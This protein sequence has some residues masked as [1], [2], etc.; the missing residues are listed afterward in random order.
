MTAK[1]LP[2]TTANGDTTDMNNNTKENNNKAECLCHE[3]SHPNQLKLRHMNLLS[4]L[5][6]RMHRIWHVQSYCIIVDATNHDIHVSSF[7]EGEQQAEYC[8][9]DWTLQARQRR[10]VAI[11][12]EP[13]NMEWRDSK[14]LILNP[15]NKNVPRDDDTK[16][17]SELVIFTP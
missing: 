17:K 9:W 1:V 8:Y 12:Y 14:D 15:P 2:I 5:C 11:G 13:H 3:K 7:Q 10:E 4:L 16:K 6:S